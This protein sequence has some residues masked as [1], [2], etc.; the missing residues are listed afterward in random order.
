[1]TYTRLSGDTINVDMFE[2]NYSGQSFIAY[3]SCLFSR[4]KL[5]RRSFSL[6]QL[7]I[8]NNSGGNNN[9]S[10]K[11]LVHSEGHRSR[12]ES[13]TEWAFH[14]F[15]NLCFILF[16][17]LPRLDEETHTWSDLIDLARDRVGLRSEPN[18]PTDPLGWC[19]ITGNRDADNSRDW[20][21]KL[22]NAVFDCKAYKPEGNKNVYSDDRVKTQMG[23]FSTNKTTNWNTQTERQTNRHIYKHQMLKNKKNSSGSGRCRYQSAPTQ[24]RNSRILLS[25]QS[26]SFSCIAVSEGVVTASYY[27]RLSEWKM[28]VLCWVVALPSPLTS[29]LLPWQ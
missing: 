22:N 4:V 9:T 18:I 11:W 28:S 21:H 14:Y 2:L 8:T 23:T 12:R 15:K 16:S 6:F 13:F 17:P 20:K 24:N 19:P 29:S 25:L 1:M 3:R 7:S 27:Y 26:F 10:S 5:T